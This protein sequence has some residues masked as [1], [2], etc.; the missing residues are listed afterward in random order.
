MRN[1]PVA[2][3]KK[4]HATHPGQCGRNLPG[5]DRARALLPLHPRNT[6]GSGEMFIGRRL[7]ASGVLMSCA[8]RARAI[9]A[10]TRQSDDNSLYLLR[11]DEGGGGVRGVKMTRAAQFLRPP[12]EGR[13]ADS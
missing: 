13:Y 10:S 3:F 11:A 12:G 1:D 7:R 9:S 2:A 4:G 6:T 5:G 8:S